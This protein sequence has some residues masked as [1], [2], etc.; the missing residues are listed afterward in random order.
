VG[1][2]AAANANPGGRGR[3]DQLQDSFPGEVFFGY[4]KTRQRG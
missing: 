3:L 2:D 4:G 1:W